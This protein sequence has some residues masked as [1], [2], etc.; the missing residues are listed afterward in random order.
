MAR[1]RPLGSERNSATRRVVEDVK[2]DFR[3]LGFA[4]WNKYYLPAREVN[5]IT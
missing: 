5:Q 2:L 1:Q 3:K 4:K